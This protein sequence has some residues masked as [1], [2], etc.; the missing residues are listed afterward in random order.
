MKFFQSLLVAPAALGLLAPNL[1]NAAEINLEDFS[2]YSDNGVE[3][4]STLSELY[5]SDWSYKAI[6]DVVASRECNDLLP[7][8]PISRF[9]A[10][11]IINS[12]L[13]GFDQ[14]TYLERRLID[15]FS[16]ELAILASR[17]DIPD[18][19]FDEFA[20]GSFSSTTV[21]SFSADFA[22]GAVDGAAN[23]KTSF[24]YGYEVG[25]TTSFTG[26]DSLDVTLVAGTGQLSE[27]DLSQDQGDT[28]VVD[29]I[30]YTLPLGDKLTAFVSDGVE[31]S[32]LFNTACIYD[33]P[34]DTLS[35]CGAVS[36]AIDEDAAI[37]GGA[38]YDFGNGLTASI[39]YEG[40][41]DTASG[42]AT[43]EGK[44]S[45]AG[46]LA[47]STDDYGFSVTFAEIEATTTSDDQFTAFN[48]FLNPE[49][50]GFPSISF[51]YEWGY[52]GDAAYAADSSASY[53]LGLQWDE[54]GEGTLG[55]AAGTKEAMAENVDDD[56]LMYEAWYTYPIND[57]MS[58]TPLV[59]TK[60][61]A[62]GTDDELGFMVKTSFS[63]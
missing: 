53:F 17:V 32:A 8:G 5:P 46:Q 2:R 35:S 56:L 48:A 19:R 20:A 54:L 4:S 51:G 29:A 3:S 18:S 27:F 11:V 43:K 10:A 61:N 47:Y 15:E 34:S 26:E 45:I 60:D 13:K 28:L 38:T 25:L 44:D 50:D 39:G 30:S 41:G 62:S 9:E 21:A 37:S 31:G 16:D 52:D 36:S 63:F 24:D 57:G 22:I 1:L 58:I 33:G 12:C 49:Q 7:Y 59:Y 42:L 14:I 40:E 55:L 6:R 23:Q